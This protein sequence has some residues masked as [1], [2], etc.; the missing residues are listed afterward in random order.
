ME[1]AL[2]VSDDGAGWRRIA[3]RS[4][5]R[6]TSEAIDGLAVT[7]RMVRI[8]CLR[9]GPHPL[10]SIWELE[11]P[12][13]A[14]AE[15]IARIRSEAAAARRADILARCQAAGVTQ[16][17]F[18]A[19]EN[20]PDGH[21]Y[22]NFSYYADDEHR[23]TYRKHGR[24]AVLDLASGTARRLIDNPE[25][26]VRDPA[27]HYDGRTILFSWR[28]GGTTSFHLYEIQA[29]GS[30][31]R[32]LTDGG[33]R[34]DDIEPAWLPDDRIVFVSSRC[35]RWVN[36]WLTQV[37]TLHRCNRDGSDVHMLSANIEHDNTPWPLPDG[38]IAY[39]RWEYIDRSQVHY[40]IFCI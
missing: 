2:E 31:L 40:P 10:Y 4:D 27:V 25:G 8:V 11:F 32:Q 17:V 23:V 39:M 29:D 12:A 6:G 34:Y 3:Y 9:P 21:W 26:T 16:I 15:Q 38:R 5:G 13:P 30:G 22:A 19:R 20:G 7:S 33:G 18:A 35:R 24:L 36:C 1:Y 14:S 37:A 28:R